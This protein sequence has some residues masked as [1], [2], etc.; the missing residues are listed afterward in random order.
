MKQVTFSDQSLV[1]MNQVGKL[2]QLKLMEAISD[3][4]F[5]N[6]DAIVLGRFQRGDDTFYRLRVGDLRCYFSIDG[7]AIHV[8]YLLRQ[9]SFSDFLFRFKL[10][11]NDE[12][13]VEEHPTFWKYLESL[14]KK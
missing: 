7:D 5:N 4:D 11:V 8:H 3:V 10:P 6:P 14:R 13:L 9:H 2:E 12:I 1:E